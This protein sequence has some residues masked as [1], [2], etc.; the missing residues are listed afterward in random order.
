MQRFRKLFDISKQKHDL[1]TKLNFIMCEKRYKV[2]PQQVI[3]FMDANK[4]TGQQLAEYLG[5]TPAFISNVR[6]GKSWLPWDYV[7]KIME[8]SEWN[9]SFLQ[10]AKYDQSI[11]VNEQ[12][13]LGGNTT[14]YY[15]YATFHGEGT[16]RPPIPLNQY[17][18]IIAQKDEEIAKKDEEIKRLNERVDKIVS[19]MEK[20]LAQSE[21]GTEQ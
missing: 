10:E 1:L 16:S 6:K 2:Y 20:L 8:N 19:I 11:H 17:E 13:V 15:P 14:F 18:D 3:D 5:V 4:L 9:T 7:V 21:K 12:A